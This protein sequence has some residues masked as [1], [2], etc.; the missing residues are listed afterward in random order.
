MF[1]KNRL[2]LD[3]E[4]ANWPHREK[5]RVV[6]AAGL[7][8]HVQVLGEGPCLLLLHGTSASTHSWRGVMPIL[9]EH[10]TVIA[11]DLPGHGFTGAASRHQMTLDGMARGITALLAELDQKP[12]LVVGHSAGAAIATWAAM[13]GLI[14]PKAIV[15]I[16]GALLP[17]KGATGVIFPTVARAL[18]LNPYVPSFFAKRADME[19]VGRLIRGT[20]SEI[21]EEGIDFY[22]TLIAN[23]GHAGAALGMMANWDLKPLVRRLP[24]FDTPLHLIVGGLDEAVEPEDADTIAEKAPSAVIHH[25]PERGHLAHE[26]DP[27]GVAALILDIAREAGACDQN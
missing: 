24:T 17:F 7:E 3:K 4:G 27:A 11:L 14:A 16:N 8:W 1:E 25:L 6:R 23:P 21:D 20:G 5:S 9:A 15:A 12:A 10:F 13:E 26:E 22:V 19:S 2:S 18:F